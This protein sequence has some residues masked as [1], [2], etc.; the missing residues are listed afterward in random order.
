MSPLNIQTAERSMIHKIAPRLEIVGESP[1][2]NSGMAVMIHGM[3]ELEIECLPT[4]LFDSIEVD[5]SGLESFSDSI[6]VR[7]LPIP[8]RVTVLADPDDVVVS[9]VSSRVAEIE[10]EVEEVEEYEYEYGVE[11]EE[12]EEGAP[13]ED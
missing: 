6:L 5:V 3:S 13:E 10:E 12:E 8:E 11:E 4:D 2:V 1:L 7:D 9:V